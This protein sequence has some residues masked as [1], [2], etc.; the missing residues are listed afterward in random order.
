M[1][2][3]D[4]VSLNAG[5]AIVRENQHRHSHLATCHT[6]PFDEHTVKQREAGEAGEEI[7]KKDKHRIIRD[8]V[9]LTA[10]ILGTIPTVTHC[11]QRQHL[12]A[13]SV[14]SPTYPSTVLIMIDGGRTLTNAFQVVCSSSD[15]CIQKW[16]SRRC[17]GASV[18]LQ[19]CLPS[20]QQLQGSFSN[21]ES[22]HRL[23]QSATR[24]EPG[25]CPVHA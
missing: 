5:P 21:C 9:M 6:A 19:G 14:R 16:R 1:E 18:R 3:S 13:Q 11:H 15:T 25:S 17:L 22:S 7:G 20:F 23:L 4:A 24:T 10:H 12:A 8:K 2:P